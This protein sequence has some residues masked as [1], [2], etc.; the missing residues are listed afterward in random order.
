[1]RRVRA[2]ALYASLISFPV[3][4]AIAFAQAGTGAVTDSS[5]DSARLNQQA[6]DLLAVAVKSNGIV[7]PDVKP[8]HM[9]IDFKMPLNFQEGPRYF[10]GSMEEQYASQ[11]RWHRTYK[12][13][14][15]GWN[16][17]E[18]S[19]SKVDRY[20]K[21]DGLK[22]LEDYTLMFHVVR[23]LTDPLFQVAHIKPTDELVVKKMDM[24]NGE[25][26]CVSLSPK[27]AAE[28][29]KRPEWLVP[30]M[31]FDG[32][33]HLRLIRSEESLLHFDDIQMIQGR[34][35]ARELTVD[36]GGRTSDQI[37]I[38]VSLLEPTES[39]DE[40][41]LKPPADAVLRPYIVERGM[42][43]PVSVYEEGAHIT[44]VPNGLPFSGSFLVPVFIQKDGTVKLQ[45]DVS[46]DSGYGPTMKAIYKAVSKWKFQPYL[47]DGQPVE[48]DY[49]VPYLTDGKPFVPSYQR[50]REP[51]DDVAGGYP[52]M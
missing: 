35:I 43:K 5:L 18:W 44:Q 45:R 42:P 23:P 37:A 4:P 7:G 11:Y 13:E 12:S 49:Y 10:K 41:I 47:V 51:G 50:P 20:T 28:R 38:K 34:A 19:A 48:V 21:K 26:N 24:G 46:D 2:F 6:R 33:T 16:G 36:E 17:S 9:K 15:L 31:C 39:I 32:E 1:M 52:G 29:G 30:M 8:W 22:E 14:W 25:L 40:G 3:T 27:S